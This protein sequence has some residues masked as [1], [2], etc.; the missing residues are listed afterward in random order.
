MEIATN[1]AERIAAQL[2][3]TINQNINLMNTKGIIIASSD[4]SRVGMEHGGAKKILKEHLEVLTVE[5]NKTF[6]G[7]K[8]GINLPIV[9]ENEVVGIIGITGPVNEV[10]QYGKIIKR[11]TEILLLENI[12]KEQKVIEQKAKERFFD[13]WVLGQLDV[14]NE[15]EFLRI[16]S[17]FSI[18]VN[19]KVRVAVLSFTGTSPISDTTMTEISR[20]VRHEVTAKLSGNAFRTATHMVCIIPANKS[21][22]CEEVFTQIFSYIK[23]HFGCIGKAG[24]DESPCAF[25][26]H[27]NYI[28]AEK[29]LE[30]CHRKDTSIEFFN[31]LDI[32]Y[33]L[34]NVPNEGRERYINRLFGDTSKEEIAEQLQ[35]ARYYLESNGSLISLSEKLFIHKNTVKY[36]INKLTELTGV[37]IRTCRGAYIFTLALELYKGLKEP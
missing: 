21:N 5:D 31:A 10:L 32:E 12:A 29:A 14:K 35:F 20:H 6:E 17:S 1:I 15:K 25:S 24:I 33:I 27:P 37:D 4:P 7:A 11:M 8:N 36:K 3:E 18:D 23:E 26:L 34:D 2:S 16:A 30:M 13:E 9:I 22:K 19:A 28:E